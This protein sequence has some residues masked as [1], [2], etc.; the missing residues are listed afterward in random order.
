MLEPGPAPQRLVLAL[1][2]LL[3]ATAGLG[4]QEPDDDSGRLAGHVTTDASSLSQVNVFAYDLAELE[5]RKATTD[6]SGRFDF[7]SLP[8]GLYKLIAFKAGFEPAIVMLSRAAADVTQ[9]VELALEKQTVGDLRQGEGYW[10]LRDQ[11]PPDVLREIQQTV[12]TDMTTSHSSSLR[13]PAFAGKVD[14]TAGVDGFTGAEAQLAGASLGMAGRIGSM[15]IGLTSE[16][17]QLESTNPDLPAADGRA[18]TLSLAM[19][20]VGQ[21]RV[22]MTSINQLR[23]GFDASRSESDYERYAVSWNQPI[24]Q[25]MSSRFSAQYYEQSNF[26]RQGSLSP[27]DVP[28]ASRVLDLEGGYEIA[29]SDRTSLTTGIRYQE[30]DQNLVGF[31]S[32]LEPLRSVDIYGT[33]GWRA[34]PT[35]LVEYGVVSRLQDGQYAL[36]PQG[37]VVVQL[38]ERWQAAGTASQRIDDGETQALFTPVRYSSAG[39]TCTNLDQ[40]CYRVLFSHQS[41]KNRQALAFGAVHRELADTLQL[42][43]NDDFFTQVDQL[44]LVEGD[45]VPEIQVAYQRNITP[46]ILARLE[47]NYAAG[48]GGVLYATDNRPYENRVRYLVTSLDTRF[49]RS[50]TG[51]FLAFHHL[52]QDLEALGPA[53][54][55]DGGEPM[56]LERVQVMLSQDLDVLMQ[57]AADWSLHLNVELSRGALPFSLTDPDSDELRRRVTGGLSVK[58]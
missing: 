22:D 45:R 19:S 1:A 20:G 23:P 52:Q 2:V 34:R 3:A 24:G 57:M 38:G 46:Q 44:Y 27:R 42:Y 40:H 13:S 33:A 49:E 48:G 51:I 17:W 35:V 21:G 15:D 31:P 16:Y 4:A 14:T 10:S 30:G 11:I 36:A 26:F 41:E 56:A 37:S 29:I 32:G 43:F 18:T 55:L 50:S 47:S 39:S 53:A 9:F 7:A 54:G 12:L 6:V 28:I 25:R 5:M 8:A 58:F